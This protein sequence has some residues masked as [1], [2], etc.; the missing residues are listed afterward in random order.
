MSLGGPGAGALL[1]DAM[2]FPAASCE[3]A[4]RRRH[5]AAASLAPSLYSTFALIGFLQGWQWAVIRPMG[6]LTLFWQAQGLDEAAMGG[7]TAMALVASTIGNPIFGAISDLTG[8]RRLVAIST[9][10]LNSAVR[11]SL[12]FF[13]PHWWIVTAIVGTNVAQGNFGAWMAGAM[14]RVTEEG[15]GPR[16]VEGDRERWGRLRLW[17]G[18]GYATGSLVTGVVNAAM[19]SPSSVSIFYQDAFTTIA[20]VLVAQC[21]VPKRLFETDDQP[22]TTSTSIQEGDDDVKHSSAC[23]KVCGLCDLCDGALVLFFAMAVAMGFAYAAVDTYLFLRLKELGGDEYLMGSAAVVQIASELPCFY[24]S[25][26]LYTRF[27]CRWLQLV[28]L[29]LYGGRQ[30]WSPLTGAARGCAGCQPSYCTV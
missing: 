21:W 2:L 4:S 22:Q 19:D 12:L 16:S 24:Y 1:C 15:D 7:T 23:G 27:G 11:C 9:T 18:V 13:A 3:A 5:A 14:F 17:G 26:A 20:L 25:G 8:Q 28:S 6:F 10:L 29:V 30:L